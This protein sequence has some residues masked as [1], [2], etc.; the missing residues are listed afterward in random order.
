ME[1]TIKTVIGQ[2]YNMKAFHFGWPFV[3]E[4]IS[5]YLVLDTF[6]FKVSPSKTP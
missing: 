6:D 4:K 5:G 1:N 3:F 2:N